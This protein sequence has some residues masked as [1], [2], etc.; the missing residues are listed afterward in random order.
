MRSRRNSV[1]VKLSACNAFNTYN[2][3]RHPSQFVYVCGRLKIA[4]LCLLSGLDCLVYV[5]SCAYWAESHTEQTRFLR[6]FSAGVDK[7]NASMLRC[8]YPRKRGSGPGRTRK[9]EL[10]QLRLLLQPGV[11][12]ASELPSVFRG[13]QCVQ[14]GVSLIPT[15]TPACRVAHFTVHLHF[16]GRGLPLSQCGSP[17]SGNGS[18][19][20]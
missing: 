7:P 3:S 4:D 13:W 5:A 8:T 17:Y 2:T 10:C 9:K 11:V 18:K 19:P 15:V 20:V 14:P 1:T 6:N 16:S 12:I